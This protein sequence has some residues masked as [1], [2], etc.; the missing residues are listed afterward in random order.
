MQK[1]AQKAATRVKRQMGKVTGGTKAKIIPPPSMKDL[2]SA[3]AR[4]RVSFLPFYVA[5]WLREFALGQKESEGKG[6]VEG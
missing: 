5:F 1:S 2:H 4:P 6:R 3:A